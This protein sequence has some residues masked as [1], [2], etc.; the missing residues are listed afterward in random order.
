[1]E[2][3]RLMSGVD[4]IISLDTS[5]C[6]SKLEMIKWKPSWI[7]TLGRRSFSRLMRLE[8]WLVSVV[9]RR[10]VETSTA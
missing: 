6:S 4:A 10:T 2:L 9:H 7:E 5:P 1:M 3:R 8:P